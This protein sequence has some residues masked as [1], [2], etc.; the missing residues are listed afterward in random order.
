VSL[1]HAEEAQEAM[2]AKRKKR[3]GLGSSAVTHTAE[4]AKASERIGHT[5]AALINAARHGRCTAATLSYAEMQQ[6]IGL[7]D[8]H[9][10]SGGKAWKPATA[11]HDAAYEYNEHCVRDSAHAT[12]VSGR[13]RRK[14]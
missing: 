12:A 2:M 6:A 4:A 1:D 13:R 14:R 9:V 8:A 5:A 10:R 3:G 11:I 7:F